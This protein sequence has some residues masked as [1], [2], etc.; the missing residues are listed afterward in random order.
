MPPPLLPDI[1]AIG[2]TMV[3]IAPA[4][5][6]PLEEAVDFHLDPGGAEA[7]VASHLAALGRRAAWA[8]RVGDDA[9]GRRLVRQLGSRGVDTRWVGI[10]ADAPTGVYFKDPGRGVRY[11]RAGSAASRMDPSLLDDLPLDTARVVH[12]SGITPALSASCDALAEAVVDRVSSALVSFDVNHRPSLW[13]ADAAPERLRSLAA[14]SDLVFVGLDEAMALWGTDTAADVRAL[15]PQPR[16][17]VVKDAA[18]L[19]TEFSD[20]GVAEVPAFEV[21]VVEPVGAGDAFAAGYLDALLAGS[22]PAERLAAGHARAVTVLSDTA[23]FPR[24]APTP[25]RIP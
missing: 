24:D 19:A 5:A 22:T 8:G 11:Y 4:L 20:S 23:D 2:E 13:S 3:L 7:N 18:A 17:L 6:E 16:L 21:D 10:D 25:R 9:L 1:V 14:R 15:L 12:L